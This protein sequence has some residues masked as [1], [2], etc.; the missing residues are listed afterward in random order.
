LRIG[1]PL[2][3]RRDQNTQLK[4]PSNIDGGADSYR[5]LVLLKAKWSPEWPGS[6]FAELPCCRARRL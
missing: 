3:A 2:K 6:T 1:S 5:R 4:V